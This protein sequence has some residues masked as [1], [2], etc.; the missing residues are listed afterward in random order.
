MGILAEPAQFVRDLKLS[1]G[2]SVCELGD[3]WVTHETT[4]RLAKSFYKELGAARY[5]SV[6]GNGRGTFTYDLNI[7][8]VNKDPRWKPFDLVTDFG[9]GEHVFNQAQVW[10]TLHVLTRPKGYIVFDRPSSGYPGHCFY[11]IQQTLVEDLAEANGYD[12]KRLEQA[13][14]VRGSLLRGVLYKRY[15]S[16][17]RVPQQGRYQKSLQ[18][19]QP[20]TLRTK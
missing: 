14:T 15:N 2:F 9:T 10:R 1:K 5:E 16:R 6:D 7:K 13:E 3:Q 19:P 8:W 4:H 11:L 17:F 18:I 20:Q 12:I